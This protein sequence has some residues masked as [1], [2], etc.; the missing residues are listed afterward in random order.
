MRK[1]VSNKNYYLAEI[2][3]KTQT[4]YSNSTERWSWDIYITATD[5]NEYIGRA[6]APGKGIEVPWTK[7]MTADYLQEMMEKCEE[8]MDAS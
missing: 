8:H 6:S 5:N 2:D 7:L 3:Y 4:A 1:E